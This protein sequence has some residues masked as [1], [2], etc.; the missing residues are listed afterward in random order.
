MG[1]GHWRIR[2]HCIVGRVGDVGTASKGIVS[3]LLTH[4]L[5][6]SP[7]TP[8]LPG[9]GTGQNNLNRDN[10]S[11]SGMYIPLRWPTYRALSTQSRRVPYRGW[12]WLAWAV[13][14]L[15]GTVGGAV[16]LA[17]LICLPTP[18]V[19]AQ[20]GESAVTIANEYA[21]KAV[22]L[23]NFGKYTE[24]PATAFADASAPFVIGILGEDLFGGALDEVAAKGTIGERR[25]VVRRFA[26]PDQ[27]RQPCHILFVS[28]SLTSGQESVLR[29][30]I[31]GDAVL[32][33]GESPGF[34]ERGG[35]INYFIEGDNIRFEINVDNARRAQLRMGAKLLRLGKPVG[36]SPSATSNY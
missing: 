22:F 33:V 11:V 8:N 27:Y 15:L 16:V 3:F 6:R 5:R 30:K 24:W 26:S 23:Y 12:Q 32:V 18:C 31:A 4:R 1:S 9:P 14:R 25:I 36:T 13:R 10:R 21:V 35:S 34:A 7:R 20:Q 19:K 29:K 2:R 28:R 17:G